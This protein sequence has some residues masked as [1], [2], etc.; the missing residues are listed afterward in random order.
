MVTRIREGTSVT[1]YLV[2]LAV[3]YGIILFTVA[4]R[5]FPLTAIVSLLTI[6]TALKVKSQIKGNLSNPYGL[7][8]A[9]SFACAL[10]KARRINPTKMVSDIPFSSLIPLKSTA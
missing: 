8:P 9:M 10:N 3:A 1:G 2:S 7:M 5:V 6:P 4:A